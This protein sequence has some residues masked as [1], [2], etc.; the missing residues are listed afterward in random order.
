MYGESE[1]VDIED[2]IMIIERGDSIDIYAEDN[3]E[4]IIE[5]GDEE[6]I[7]DEEIKTIDRDDI[8]E[9]EELL[10]RDHNTNSELVYGPTQNEAKIHIYPEYIL[11][12]TDIKYT[13]NMSETD[14]DTAE[15]IN[16]ELYGETIDEDSQNGTIE[17]LEAGKYNLSVTVDTG[18]NIYLTEKNIEVLEPAEVEIDGPTTIEVGE[19]A[20]YEYN[21]NENYTADYSVWN[22]NNEIS[23]KETFN[24][25]FINSGEKII[26]LRTDIVKYLGVKPRG[27]RPV[28]PV[29]GDESVGGILGE[30]A[31]GVVEN[32]YTTADVSAQH[33]K[34][35]VDW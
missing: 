3:G 35:G 1:D 21:L 8:S 12:N 11:E 29:E 18:S 14:I 34:G 9:N 33:N 22:Y 32:V 10:I 5:I 15:S 13:V 16:L 6:L 31:E 30:N 20:S 4:Y 17:P 24:Y 25:S 19:E 26:E 23:E 2:N 7:I 28:H 27:T